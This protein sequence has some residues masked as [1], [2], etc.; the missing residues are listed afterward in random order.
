MKIENYKGV[1]IWHNASSDEFYTTM[2]VLKGQHGRKDECITGGRLQKVRNDIDKFLNTAAKKP[3]MKRAWL[4]SKYEG[5]EYELVDIII[6][7]AISDSVHIRYKNGR[8]ENL[9]KSEYNSEKRLFISC[10]EN[11]AIVSGLN[12]K[13]REMAKMKKEMSCP[14][15]KLIPLCAEHFS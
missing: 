14:G 6:Y 3:V 8:T 13:I 7:N 2:V 15:G 5:G 4:K 1:D 9:G 12:K 10:K 11:D